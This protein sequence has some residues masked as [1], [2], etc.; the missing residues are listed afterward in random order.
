MTDHTTEDVHSIVVQTTAG[1]MAAIPI[2][3]LADLLPTSAAPQVLGAIWT[4]ALDYLRNNP[5]LRQQI[6]TTIA[7]TLTDLIMMALD[8]ALA[9]Q[10]AQEVK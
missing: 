10:P 1:K 9:S 2:G 7:N 5:Q 3:N 4:W 8:K 6:A